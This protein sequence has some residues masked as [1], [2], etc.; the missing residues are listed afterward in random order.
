[1]LVS[2]THT[3][4]GVLKAYVCSFGSMAGWSVHLAM[5]AAAPAPAPAAGAAVG[6]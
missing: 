1:M 2:Y 6:G 5:E 3:R 4:I